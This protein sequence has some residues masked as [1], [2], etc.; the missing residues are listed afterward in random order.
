MSRLGEKAEGEDG[1]GGAAAGAAG[2]VE[3]SHP[4]L[5]EATKFESD[6]Y[7]QEH[8]LRS[9]LGLTHVGRGRRQE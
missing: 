4:P 3:G 2:D 9:S 7:F 5:R 8:A 6:P 1:R